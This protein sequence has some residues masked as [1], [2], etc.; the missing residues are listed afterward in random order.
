M[1]FKWLR[2]HDGGAT[3]VDYFCMDECVKNDYVNKLRV[4]I[5]SDLDHYISDYYKNWCQAPITEKDISEDRKS[6]V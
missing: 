5:P 2:N 6:V 3:G 4:C 1:C